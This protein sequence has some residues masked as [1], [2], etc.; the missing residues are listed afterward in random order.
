MASGGGAYRSVGPKSHKDRLERESH[1]R[2]RKPLP[3]R[4]EEESHP[5]GHEM[6]TS[7]GGKRINSC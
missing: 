4:L 6:S 1:K 5:L 2:S 7:V 3:D